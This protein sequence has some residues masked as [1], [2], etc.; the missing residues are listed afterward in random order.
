ML[1]HMTFDDYKNWFELFSYLATILGIP[2]AIIVF[3]KD[4]RNS[5]KIKEREALFTSH[6]LYVDF[7]KI[8]LEHPELEIYFFT[9]RN[10][11]YSLSKKKEMIAYEILIAYLESAYIQYADQ[12]MKVKENRW[13]GWEKLIKDYSKLD[14]FLEVW[15]LTKNDWDKDFR[16]FVDLIILKQQ[17]ETNN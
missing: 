16:L 11:D 9:Y 5:R 12:S 2:I 13:I 6:A 7:L 8:C 17:P 3:I 4:K 14:T 10:K 1:G 15:N